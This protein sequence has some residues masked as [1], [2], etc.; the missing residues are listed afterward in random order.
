MRKKEG[1][2]TMATQIAETP[3]LYGKDAEAVMK[4][5]ASKPSKRQ[6]DQLKKKLEQ[7]FD[8]IQTRRG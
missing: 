3:T 4:Q 8:G 2:H 5:V 7:K 1:K 6:V